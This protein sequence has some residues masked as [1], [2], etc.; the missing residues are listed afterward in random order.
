MKINIVLSNRIWTINSFAENMVSG[1]ILVRKRRQ[2][3]REIFRFGKGNTR[4]NCLDFH[5]MITLLK[6]KNHWENFMNIL[7]HLK[8]LDGL[9]ILIL[10]GLSQLSFW[11]TSLSFFNIL[12]TSSILNTEWNMTK[13]LTPFTHC[14][15][16]PNT[17]IRRKKMW[18]ENSK[19]ADFA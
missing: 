9:R 12:R 18:D 5:D 2:C 3:S 15:Q 14:K 13:T 6:P 7:F 19:F 11:K 1:S 8:N 17:T 10:L 16:N 4:K